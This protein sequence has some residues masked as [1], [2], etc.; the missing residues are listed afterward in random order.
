M[1]NSRHSEEK[2]CD[3]SRP[4]FKLRAGL[5]QA[6]SCSRTRETPR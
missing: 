5:S 2:P 6:F 1:R 3:L 4:P